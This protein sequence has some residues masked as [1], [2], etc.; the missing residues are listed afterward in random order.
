MEVEFDQPDS[1]AAFLDAFPNSALKREFPSAT[2]LPKVAPLPATQVKDDQQNCFVQIWF[3]EGL[4]IANKGAAQ[5]LVQAELQRAKACPKHS[6]LL[7]DAGSKGESFSL[8]FRFGQ[9]SEAE[10]LVQSV[11]QSVAKCLSGQ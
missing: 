5:E 3:R 2:C 10:R 11:Q 8:V 7:K 4:V 6:Q 9:K 1:V